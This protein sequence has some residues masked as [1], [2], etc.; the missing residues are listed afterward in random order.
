MLV[1]FSTCGKDTSLNSSKCM[2]CGDYGGAVPKGA[3][4]A[5]LYIVGAL[6]VLGFI[7][8]MLAP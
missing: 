2:H 4:T 3:K 7:G 5:L 8:A 6:L 1:K